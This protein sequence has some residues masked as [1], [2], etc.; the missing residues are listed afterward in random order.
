MHHQLKRTER[1]TAAAKT[2][3]KEGTRGGP[4]GEGGRAYFAH[5]ALAAA[6]DDAA[7]VA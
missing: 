1:C 3:R 4:R 5:A 7:T 6:L 2:H